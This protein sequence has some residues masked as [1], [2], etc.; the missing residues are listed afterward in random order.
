MPPPFPG[1]KPLSALNV[2]AGYRDFVTNERLLTGLRKRFE[3]AIGP[4]KNA[5]GVR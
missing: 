2:A 3:A 1:L 5:G 4:I